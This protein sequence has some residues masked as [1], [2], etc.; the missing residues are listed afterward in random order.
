MRTTLTL[1][2]D[3]YQAALHLARTSGRRLGS[4]VSELMRRGLAPPAP[5]ARQRKGRFPVFEVPPDAPLIP[6]VRVQ[7]FLDEEGIL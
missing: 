5:P 2:D 6:A 4:V 3:V 1:D 7:E